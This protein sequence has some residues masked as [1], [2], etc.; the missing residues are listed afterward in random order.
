MLSKNLI[1]YSK[2]RYGVRAYTCY[3][4]SRHIKNPV[5]QPTL[6]QITKD[7]ERLA[8]E[9]QI[10]DAMYILDAQGNLVRKLRQ[11]SC[12]LSQDS[13][14]PNYAD[15]AYFYECKKE[16]RSTLTDPYPSKN[17]GKLVVTASY[18]IYDAQG[19][20]QFIACIDLTL[21]NALLVGAPT[22]LYSAFSWTSNFAYTMLSLMLFLVAILLFVRGVY[23]FW[24]AMVHFSKLDIKEVFEATILLTLSL[25]IVDLVKAIFEE[26]VLGHNNGESHYAI[27]K[28]MIR[29][30]GSIII[31]LAIEALMLVFKFSIIEPEK[32]LYTIYLTGGVALLLFGLSVYVK[33]AYSAVKDDRIGG[34][35]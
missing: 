16:G 13:H 20:L 34:N 23:S 19:V 8:L 9:I 4:F 32:I 6:D 2:I 29:F 10:F 7:L 21:E 18:P 14:L 27:H 1:K 25:A 26:E 11:E 35:D 22:K 24:T 17:G 12:D 30:L 3:L 31:A 33:F 28:T 5:H 15:R